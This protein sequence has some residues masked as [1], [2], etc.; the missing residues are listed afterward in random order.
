[1]PSKPNKPSQPSK[2][3]LHNLAHD[4][5]RDLNSSEAQNSSRDNISDSKTSSGF[6]KSTADKHAGS[7]SHKHGSE[8]G[9]RRAPE[10]EGAGSK[11][12]GR[13]P[14]GEVNDWTK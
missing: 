9:G 6:D 12:S 3:Q 13:F 11:R 2:D 10:D 14:K 5:E 8:P 4:C 1:M 7:G